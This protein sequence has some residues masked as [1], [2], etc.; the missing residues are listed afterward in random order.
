M[1]VS[2]LCTYVPLSFQLE[3]IRPEDH[4]HITALAT[5]TEK[6]FQEL[7]D[8]LDPHTYP[9]ARAYIQNLIE[10]VTT[11]LRWW[12]YKGEAI[13]LTTNAVESAFSQV[14]NR[15]KRVGRRW[16]E[17]GLLN[18]LKVAFYKIFKPQ[19]WN[20]VWCKNNHQVPFVKLISIQSS[21]VWC[22]S[23]T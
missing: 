7:L 15:I 20:L 19:C 23:I 22:E 4:H 1:N 14:C 10:P 6:G 9:K 11:F 21:Y 3:K 8:A 2:Y 12:L 13:P 16:S 17:H 5:K 18:W